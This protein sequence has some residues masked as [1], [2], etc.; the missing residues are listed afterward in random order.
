[1]AQRVRSLPSEQ[2]SDESVLENKILHF[3]QNDKKNTVI[4]IAASAQPPIWASV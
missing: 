4:L 1:M 2:A 3:I